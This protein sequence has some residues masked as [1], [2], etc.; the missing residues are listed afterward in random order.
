MESRTSLEHLLKRHKPCWACSARFSCDADREFG[1]TEQDKDSFKLVDYAAAPDVMAYKSKCDELE[2]VIK[3]NIVAVE[4]LND[5]VNRVLKAHHEGSTEYDVDM[6]GLSGTYKLLS[7]GILELASMSME[8]ALTGL[9][10]R[11]YFDSRFNMEWKRAIRNQQEV[12]LLLLDVDRF[13]IYND[14]YGHQQGDVALRLIGSVLKGFARRPG[15]LA[16]RWGGE[17]F[18]ILLAETGAQGALAVAEQIRTKIEDTKIPCIVEGAEAITVSVGVATRAPVV[19]DSLSDL[20]FHSDRALY[21]AKELGRNRTHV[22]TATPT[23]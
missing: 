14:T 9:P 12:S 22:Y 18:I 23:G 5:N 8:D 20:V 1:C 13:K 7:Y 15:D 19:G 2:Q 4:C 10:N 17:E 11:R 21:K 3:D 6:D 16:A